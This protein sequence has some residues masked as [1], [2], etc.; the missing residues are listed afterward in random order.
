MCLPCFNKASQRIRLLLTACFVVVLFL[1]TLPSSQAQQRSVKNTYPTNG[2]VKVLLKNRAGTV[3]VSGW[4]K[5]E[6][7]ITATM[8]APYAKCIQEM[9]GNDLNIDMVRDNQGHEVGNVRFDIS[10]PYNAKVDIETLL[11][12]IAIKNIEASMVRAHITADG[13]ISLTNIKSEWVIARNGTGDIFFDGELKA[14]GTYRFN[15]VE[16]KINI[17]IPFTSSFRLSATA[18]AT[19]D[20]KLGDLPKSGLNFIDQ[21][22][23]VGNV[24]D[25]KAQL[26]ISNQRG[27]IAFLQR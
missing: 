24:G 10:V 13:D 12:D 9:N 8:E 16:G 19:G 25:G 7:K 20:I 22:K 14:G 15:S 27:S 2:N 11:G 21:R 26:T 23:V 3:V 18:P 6:I 1:S 5:N 4:S 17:R